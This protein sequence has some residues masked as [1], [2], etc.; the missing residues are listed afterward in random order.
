MK[1]II[2]A[3]AMFATL[4]VQLSFAQDSSKGNQPSALLTSY[5][6][7]KDALVSGNSEVAGAKAEEFKKILNKIEV[8]EFPIALRVALLKDS[9]TFSKTK[10]IQ[11]QRELF[12]VFSEDMYALAKTIKLSSDPIY[13][14]YCPMKKSSWLSNAVAIKNPYYGSGMLTCGKI[15][16]TIE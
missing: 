13:K 2:L 8:A 14:D 10:D 4:L 7:I 5:F 9:D 3:V 11:K 16:E 1:K 12:K 15:T 6:S